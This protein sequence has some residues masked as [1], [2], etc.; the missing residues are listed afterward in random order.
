[1]TLKDILSN[2]A[3]KYSDNQAVI[4]QKERLSYAEL[5]SLSDFMACQLLDRGVRKADRVGL[6]LENSPLYVIA[7]FSVLKAGAVVVPINTQLVTRELESIIS[8]CQ[9]SMIITDDSH[10]QSLDTFKDISIFSVS[11]IRYTPVASLQS[12]PAKESDPA[13]IIYTS[14]T[15]GKPKGVMLSHRNL[16]AN[17]ESIVDYL[18]LSSSDSMMVILP[19]Y[20]SYGNSLLTTHIMVGATLVIDNRFVFPN[21]VLE[22]MEKEKVTGF[23]GVPSHYAILLRK[24]ALR[25]Y[26]LTSLRYVTQ[27]GGGMP[28]SMI[29]EFT[30]V[31]PH[32]QFFVMY[33]QTEATARLTYLAPEHLRSKL[34][35]IGKAIPG[36]ELDVLNEQGQ[37]V[38]NGEVG[39]IVA[40]G[41]NIMLGY[42]NAAEE[43]GKVKR[44]EGLW[45]GDMA[46]VDSDGF[47]YLI[48]RKKEMIKSGANRISPLEIEDVVSRLPGV[49][50]CAAVGVPDEILGESIKLCVVKNGVPLTNND[51][52]LHCKQHLAPFKM[53]KEVA[54]VASLP[55]T[56]TGKIKRSELK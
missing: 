4:Y 34:G 28:A 47:I 39:E 18:K 23:A 21:V 13:M 3:R 10:K 20:Y 53:P 25:N 49:V 38:Q 51:I 40:R 43:T 44:K 14:G 45:T 26:K 52:L 1:M 11:S 27:A 37:P 22:T 36:V 33:G 42:W 2:S 29:K 15:T 5:E 16:V 46:K 41:N 32:A 56:S 50:E 19:F 12:I 8:D 17:A 35:S 9:P 48:S 6:L 55:K 7:F 31:V 54:F 30:E 24:S